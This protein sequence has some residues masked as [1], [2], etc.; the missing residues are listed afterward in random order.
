MLS[1]TSRHLACASVVVMVAPE[2][3]A[4]ARAAPATPAD[5]PFV[6][7]CPWP[8]PPLR[9]S[10]PRRNAAGALRDRPAARVSSSARA[11]AARS[12]LPLSAACPPR[13]PLRSAAALAGA[14]A[15]PVPLEVPQ[16]TRAARCSS[17]QACR[18]AC[19]DELGEALVR[20]QQRFLRDVVRVPL[21]SEHGHAQPTDARAVSVDAQSQR[22]TCFT[23]RQRV[24]D[25]D[26]LR[27]RDRRGLRA[28]SGGGGAPCPSLMGGSWASSSWSSPVPSEKRDR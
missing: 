23:A 20:R 19:A 12:I 16:S 3:A 22:A 14:A 21:R 13:R 1:S 2:R 28:R 27:L 10:D 6:R 11:A 5:A 18:E 26:V 24:Q 8:R 9:S 25:L 7:R 15:P 4:Q 17:S